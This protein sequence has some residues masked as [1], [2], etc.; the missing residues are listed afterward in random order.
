[1]GK[2]LRGTEIAL[3]EDKAVDLTPGSEIT[4]KYV[5]GKK[6]PFYQ[7]PFIPVDIPSDPTHSQIRLQR[8]AMP[9]GS[10]PRGVLLSEIPSPFYIREEEISGAG[11][12]VNRHWQRSRWVNGVVAQWI[13]R[14]KQFGKT[15]GNSSLEFD[16]L[17]YT[18]T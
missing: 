18:E 6:I 12:S 7:I 4:L 2:G 8:A 11:T 13:G 5:L 10:S 3:Q 14:E 15:E 17:V 16:L 9:G 1:M